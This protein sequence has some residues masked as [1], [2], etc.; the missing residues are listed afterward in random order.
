MVM[1]F[2]ILNGV[3]YGHDHGDYDGDDVHLVVVEDENDSEK[4]HGD[5][6][7]DDF[8][9]VVGEDDDGC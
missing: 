8:Y 4:V 7:G 9:L 2:L 6:D 3:N 5:D 1:M